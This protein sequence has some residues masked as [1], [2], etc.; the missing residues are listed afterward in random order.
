MLACTKDSKEV[1]E[2]LLR[3]DASLK[4][5]NKDGWAPFHIACRYAKLFVS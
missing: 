5:R 4:L 1:V 2:T 3:L